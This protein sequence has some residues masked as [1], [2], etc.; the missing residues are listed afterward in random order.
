MSPEAPDA[1]AVA[2]D[3][4]SEVYDS[5]ANR[6]RDLDAVVLRRQSFT[7]AG[8]DVLELGCGTGKNTAWLASQAASVLALDFSAGMLARARARLPAAHVRFVEHDLRDRWPADD[9]AFDR[10]VGNLVL[11]HVEQLG[12]IFAEAAR[13]LRPGGLAFFCELH[14][15]RQLSGGQAH[16]MRPDSGEVVHVTA[17]VHDVADYLNAGCAAG[18]RLVGAGDWRDDDERGSV[19]RLL[20]TLWQRDA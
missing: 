5:A 12:P 2:Y 16:F 9:G 1:V 6:T 14:P 4:W 18:L 10:V 19:P 8:L 20:S 15:F 7:L 11:E 3:A 17:H 13:V